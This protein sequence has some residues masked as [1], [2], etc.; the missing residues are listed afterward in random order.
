VPEVRVSGFLIGRLVTGKPITTGLPGTDTAARPDH[1]RAEL[2]RRG[3]YHLTMEIREFLGTDS[4]AKSKKTCRLFEFRYNQ[5]DGND[6]LRSIP[7]DTSHVLRVFALDGATGNEIWHYYPR[8]G[9]IVNEIA[10]SQLAR[11]VAFGSPTAIRSTFRR[12]TRG[13]SPLA[14]RLPTTALSSVSSSLPR[15][16]PIIPLPRAGIALVLS[17]T[18]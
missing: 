16:M 12:M 18:L 15:S 9:D 6:S 5:L 3:S 8:L 14:Y 17:T 1:K 10:F 4:H 7:S 11:G 13:T 2:C